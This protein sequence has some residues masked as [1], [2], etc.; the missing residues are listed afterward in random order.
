MNDYLNPIEREARKITFH[1]TEDVFRVVYRL[2]N[3]DIAQ[4]VE[5]A[6]LPSGLTVDQ[7]ANRD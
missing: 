2:T 5:D 3:L 7:V 4:A 6:L 1:S